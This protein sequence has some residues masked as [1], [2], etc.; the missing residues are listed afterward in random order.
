[1]AKLK[2][3]PKF[4]RFRDGNK[5]SWKALKAKDL[6]DADTPDDSDDYQ[7]MDDYTWET[8]QVPIL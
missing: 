5:K 4:T 7:Q 2:K 3:G 6:G 1:V 8:I